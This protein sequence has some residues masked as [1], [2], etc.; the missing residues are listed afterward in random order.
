[1]STPTTPGPT[2]QLLRPTRHCKVSTVAS[3]TD[4][5]IDWP[6]EAPAIS[7]REAWLCELDRVEPISDYLDPA[8]MIYTKPHIGRVKHFIEH[9]WSDPISIDVG[10][11]QHDDIWWPI[12]DGNHRLCAAVLREDEWIEVEVAGDLDYANSVLSPQVNW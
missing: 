11:V 3:I 7:G 1:M 9:G 5:T 2:R 12:E 6:W 10:F 4:P 8:H